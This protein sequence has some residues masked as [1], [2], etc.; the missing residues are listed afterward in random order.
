M[1]YATVLFK[2]L[3]NH[4]KKLFFFS[5]Y[6]II[7]FIHNY[8]KGGS[9]MLDILFLVICL[10]IAVPAIITPQKM[11][12]RE[13]SKIKSEMAVRVCGVIIVVLGLMNL[14]I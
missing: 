2:S 12:Q 6:A 3:M 9:T 14:L 1:P 13:G 5:N 10:V 4:G 7:L 8:R 11:T